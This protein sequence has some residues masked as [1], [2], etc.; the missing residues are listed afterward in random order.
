MYTYQI[1]CVSDTGGEYDV[2]GEARF[3]LRDAC[4]K[5]TADCG[6]GWGVVEL[7]EQ[8]R[9]VP[10]HGTSCGAAMY[11]LEEEGQA[12]TQVC[13]GTA[14]YGNTDDSG[15]PSAYLGIVS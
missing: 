2:R 3:E 13:F 1:V 6:V 12:Q 4:S 14:F 5:P 15:L 11:R 10:L 8:A 9:M 7:V